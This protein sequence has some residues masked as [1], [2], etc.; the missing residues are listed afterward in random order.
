MCKL[1]RVVTLFH[2]L[3][4]ASDTDTRALL[5]PLLSEFSAC[6]TV[7]NFASVH[8]KRSLRPI[9]GRDIF[10]DFVFMCIALN[11]PEWLCFPWTQVVISVFNAFLPQLA[12][13]HL[14]FTALSGVL[15]LKREIQ[16]LF[17]AS[18][19]FYFCKQAYNV[20]ILSKKQC[21][22]KKVNHGGMK[23]N[24]IRKPE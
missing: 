5:L 12:F 8:Y 23:E 2:S 17:P 13:Y 21:H 20:S 3:Q 9:V 11:C 4:H 6:R 18:S 7:L 19:S 1:P 10:L 14:Q 24:F 16:L 22:F 15:F